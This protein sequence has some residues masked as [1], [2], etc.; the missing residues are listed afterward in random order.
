[1]AST[2]STSGAPPTSSSHQ[3]RSGPSSESRKRQR[4]SP[5]PA[6]VSTR[7][8][9]R[10]PMPPK[11]KKTTDRYH[12]KRADV[13]PEDKAVKKALE[14]H[15]RDLWGLLQSSDVPLTPPDE[16]RASFDTRYGPASGLAELNAKLR[17]ALPQE[18]AAAMVR[19]YRAAAARLRGPI[20][21]N[22][23]RMKESLQLVMFS[24]VLSAG[25]EKWHPDV[26]GTPDSLY[27]QVHQ[28]VALESFKVIAAAYG[29]VHMGVD[30][31]KLG[32]LVMIQQFF[33]SFLFSYM[34][35]LARKELRKGPGAVRKS[36]DNNN[37]YRRRLAMSRHRWQFLVAEQFP[38]RALGIV[39]DVECH[40]DDEGPLPNPAPSPQPGVLMPPI[41]VINNKSHHNPYITDFYRSVDAERFEAAKRLGFFKNLITEHS[42]IVDPIRAKDSDISRRF[43]TQKV[44]VDWFDPEKFNKLL[45]SIRTRYRNSGVVL[46]LPSKWSEDWRGLSDDDFMQKYGSEVLKLYKLPT[47][48]DVDE[49]DEQNVEENLMEEDEI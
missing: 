44:T 27:N 5:S 48:A 42:R 26:L 29:Y 3:A 15:C 43:P 45:F 11:P 31:T 40:S 46:P 38:K 9:T 20:A 16:L 22:T 32:N 4:T 33:E 18:G 10:G 25:L 23:L 17:K 21:K 14:Q 1:M 47:D 36:I 37:A 24:A 6:T 39:A 7:K 34:A 12:L 19:S 49:A 2:S 41:Y 8:R 35:D 30:T 13:D 28:I